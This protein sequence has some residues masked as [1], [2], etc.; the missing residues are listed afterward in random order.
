MEIFTVLAYFYGLLGVFL[1]FQR[2]FNFFVCSLLLCPLIILLYVILFVLFST[3]NYLFCLFSSLRYSVF[4]STLLISS[5]RYFS[6]VYVPIYLLFMLSLFMSVY[7]V[8]IYYLLFIS[9]LYP[10]LSFPFIARFR[11]YSP[12][13]F[14]QFR[15]IQPLFRPISPY[16]LFFAAFALFHPNSP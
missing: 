6:S 9:Y 10:A 12:P 5:L 3:L 11:L 1:R 16:Q 14:A 7:V 13:D 4:V 2:I 8:S 15:P